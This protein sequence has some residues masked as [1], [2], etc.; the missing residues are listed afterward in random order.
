MARLLSGWLAGWL[1]QGR[2]AAGAAVWLHAAADGL[3]LA[4]HWE[5]ME[6]QLSVCELD[7]ALNV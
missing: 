5:V 7:M 6:M 1:V 4:G 3:V 2:R